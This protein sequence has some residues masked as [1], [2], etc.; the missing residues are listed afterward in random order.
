MTRRP[1]HGEARICYTRSN[2]VVQTN[3]TQITAGS[4]TYSTFGIEIVEQLPTTVTVVF[5]IDGQLLR[6]ATTG[7]VIRH[8]SVAVASASAMALTSYVKCGSSSSETLNVDWM[9]A[10]AARAL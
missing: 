1:H 2:G 6:D 10:A 4:T 5:K 8:P 7:Q 9:G 3:T